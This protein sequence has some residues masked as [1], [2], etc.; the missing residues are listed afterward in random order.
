MSAQKLADRCSELG[1]SVP[2]A[3]IANLENGHRDSVTV[4]ELLVLAAALE[5]PPAELFFPFGESLAAEFLPGGRAGLVDAARWLGGFA[6][7]DSASMT[8][9]S[10]TVVYPMETAV[11]LYESHEAAASHLETLLRRLASP[12]PNPDV[13]A[14]DE[15]IKR[16][17]EEH[18]QM[19]RTEMRRR[20]L[21]L[22]PLADKLSYV[23]PAGEEADDDGAH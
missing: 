9:V 8:V 10:P 19:I 2:R 15:R 23:E 6:R 12:H 17:E 5:V 22:P 14:A 7:L 18:L 13:Q 20:G 21:L 16:L 1:L 11:Q 3:V 4:A